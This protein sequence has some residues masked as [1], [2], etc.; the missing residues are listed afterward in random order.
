MTS[1]LETNSSRASSRASIW[2][3]ATSADAIMRFFWRVILPLAAGLDKKVKDCDKVNLSGA[4]NIL[5]GMPGKLD[6][7][8]SCIV[9]ITAYCVLVGCFNDIK[10]PLAKKGR[11]VA[12]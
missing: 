9:T 11:E 8:Y 6:P 5:F 10:P 1:R 3:V 4:Q 12:N 7:G 2:L